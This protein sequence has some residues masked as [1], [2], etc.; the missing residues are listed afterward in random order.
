MLSMKTAFTLSLLIVLMSSAIFFEEGWSWVLTPSIAIDLEAEI[1]S[2][3]LEGI[4]R[5]DQLA[6]LA[7]ELETSQYGGMAAEMSSEK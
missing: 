1:A 5:G 4:V 2:E 3:I 7:R 6:L